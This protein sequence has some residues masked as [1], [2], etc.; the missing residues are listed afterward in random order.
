[1]SNLTAIDNISFT[2]SVI[3]GYSSLLHE[4]MAEINQ[5]LKENLSITPTRIG[6][7]TM[8][9]SKVQ[10]GERVSLIIESAKNNTNN[11]DEAVERIISRIDATISAAIAREGIDTVFLKTLIELKGIFIG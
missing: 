10:A 3:A 7:L 5:E 1:M 8:L 9:N 11:A 6:C 2:H 4:V